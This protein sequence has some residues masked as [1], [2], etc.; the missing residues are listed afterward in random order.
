M[1]RI[2]LD[3]KEGEFL[4]EILESYLSD[5]KTERAHTDK[6]EMRL[7]LKVREAMVTGLIEQIKS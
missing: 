4:A 7:E 5:L 2:E 3:E 1:K 6:R